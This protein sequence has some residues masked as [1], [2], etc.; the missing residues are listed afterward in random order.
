MLGY[1]N[2]KEETEKSIKDN[3]FQTGDAGY[4][5]KDGFIFVKDRI[6]DVVISG[7]ENIYSAEVENILLEHPNVSEVSVIGLPD[8]KWGE[9][10]TAIIVAFDVHKNNF[11]IE[12]IRFCDDKLA[13]FKIPKKFIYIKTLPKT[14]SGKVLKNEIRKI[15]K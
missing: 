12:L 15:Q 4:I 14:A 10:V 3:W 2:N 1:W 6:K 11:D 13:K 7:G 5:D 8:I 9:V